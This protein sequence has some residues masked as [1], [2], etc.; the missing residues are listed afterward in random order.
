VAAAARSQRQLMVCYN[1]R[2]RPDSQWVKQ[3]VESGKLGTIYHATVSWRRETGIPGWGVFGSK[4]L[5]GGG[6]LI[7]LGV[8]VLDLGLWMM[9]FP[10]VKTISADTRSVFGK[11]GRKTWLPQGAQQPPFEVE[12][13]GVAFLRLANGASMLLNVTWAEHGRPHQDDFRIELQG[14]EGTA[15]LHVQNYGKEDTLRFYTELEGQPTTVIPSL[16]WSGAMGHEALVMDLVASLRRESEP[17]TNG[18][19]GLAAVKILQALYESAAQGYE[20]RL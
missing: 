14:S 15:I 20:V 18:A 5:S 2:Y 13:G 11:S 19:Q 4:A 16:N 17:A 6:A 7:D 1:Y 3:M 8:H 10:A 12:D 9:D